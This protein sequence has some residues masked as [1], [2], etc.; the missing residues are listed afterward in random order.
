MPGPGRIP[1]DVQK[2]AGSPGVNLL[3]L[4]THFDFTIALAVR[5]AMIMAP[6]LRKRGHYLKEHTRT[7]HVFHGLQ[8]LCIC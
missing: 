1:A 7:I 2:L 3:F 5:R 6:N 8:A 4:N